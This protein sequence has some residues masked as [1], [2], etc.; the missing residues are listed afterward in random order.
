MKADGQKTYWG[1]AISD[2]LSRKIKRLLGYDCEL[3]RPGI[4]A[5]ITEQREAAVE[6]CDNQELE[7][8]NARQIMLKHKGA[9]GSGIDLTF[10]KAKRS[11]TT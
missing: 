8:Y 9:H 4:N 7:G 5:R 11:K 10:R 3:R 2:D 6:I 1:T